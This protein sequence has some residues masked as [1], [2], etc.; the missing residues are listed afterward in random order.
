MDFGKVKARSDRQGP[1]QAVLYRLISRPA[2]VFWV[3][4]GL[5]LLTWPG[6]YTSGDGAIKIDWARGLLFRGSSRLDPAIGGEEEY[7]FYSI[8]HTLLAMPPLIISHLSRELLGIRCEAALYTFLFVV[9]GATLLYLVARYLWP[10][11]G[12]RR[13]WLTVALLG[14]GSFWWPYTKVDFTEPLVITVIFASFLLLRAGRP[15]LGML[16]AGAAWTLRPEAVLFAGIL[17][18]WHLIRTRRWQDIV[19]MAI[20]L[21]PVIALNLY[22]NWIRWGALSSSAYSGGYS[23]AGFDYPALAGLFGVLL[24]PG[25]GILWFSPPLLLGFM[26]WNRMRH[27]IETRLDAWLFAGLLGLSVALYA[28]WWDWGSDDAWGVRFLIPGV[29]LMIIPAVEVLDRRIWVAGIL[30]A[31]VSVQLLA[32][33]VAPLEYVMMIRTAKVERPGVFGSHAPKP[34]DIEEMWYHPRYGQLPG[35]WTLLR[36]M[37]GI[38][39]APRS[40]RENRFTGR[41][42]YEC[43]PQ[44]T[45]RKHA[46]PDLIWWAPFATATGLNRKS[47]SKP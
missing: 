29:M 39:P 21:V 47:E 44:E 43:F 22:A 6:H 15:F 14:L 20:A 10:L 1:I 38:P 11:H 16:M 18:L 31:G 42:L 12:A 35:H 17:G 41:S 9:N 36:V 23:K 19:P 45:W 25:K 37:V 33:I 30:M 3:F 34:L 7:S 32:V 8:G 28:R 2:G 46:T 5:Y 4:L 13:A 27:R 26:G 24:S 40:E